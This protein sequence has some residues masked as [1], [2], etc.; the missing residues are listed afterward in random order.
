MGQAPRPPAAAGDHLA[1]T[2][3]TFALT[4]TLTLPFALTSPLAPAQVTTSRARW[5]TR[6]RSAAPPRTPMT[7]TTLG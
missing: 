2:P 7:T 1:S 4:F 3:L 6:W 5:P